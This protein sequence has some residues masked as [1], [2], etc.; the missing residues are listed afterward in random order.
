MLPTFMQ[1]T[2]GHRWAKCDMVYTFATRRLSPVETTRRRAYG[3]RAYEYPRLDA[4]TLR[5]VRRA[6]AAGLGIDDGGQALGLLDLKR[7]SPAEAGP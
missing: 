6:V 5:A 3:K 1:A 2:G 7:Q 4:T